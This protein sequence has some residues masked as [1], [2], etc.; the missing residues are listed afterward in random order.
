MASAT[1]KMHQRVGS[2]VMNEEGG[3]ISSSGDLEN[4]ENVASIFHQM[5]KGADKTVLSLSDKA[6]GFKKLSVNYEDFSYV[7]AV[8]NKKI[9]VSKI[10]GTDS[11]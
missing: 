10:I 8:S 11:N 3:I 4:N 7:V 5:V 2:I 9:H 1:D 6:D